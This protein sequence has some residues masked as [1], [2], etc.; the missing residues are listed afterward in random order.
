MT[1]DVTWRT[2]MCA[3]RNR[4]RFANVTASD[5]NLYRLILKEVCFVHISDET[6]GD[7]H[8]QLKKEQYHKHCTTK[9]S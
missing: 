6:S 3:F 1:V 5:T 4:Q 7:W 9:H 2:F 8:I